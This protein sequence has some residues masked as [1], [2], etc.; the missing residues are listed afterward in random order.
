MPKMPTKNILATLGS[1]GRPAWL[2]V[3]FGHLEGRAGCAV[4]GVSWVAVSLPESESSSNVRIPKNSCKESIWRFGDPGGDAEVCACAKCSLSSSRAVGS[5]SQPS[6]I[7]ALR[8]VLPLTALKASKSVLAKILRALMIW[9]SA[10]AVVCRLRTTALTTGP[11][12]AVM[13]CAG[14]F[15][16]MLTTF[17]LLAWACIHFE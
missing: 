9:R 4:S 1:V 5:A 17:E 2:A 13:A 14:L 12:S 8:E 7:L 6:E 15:P 16:P 3:R 11:A 10:A